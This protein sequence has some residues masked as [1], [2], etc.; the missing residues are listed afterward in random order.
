MGVAK[1]TK[2][3]KKEHFDRLQAI[4]DHLPADFDYQVVV[5]LNNEVLS[6]RVRNVRYGRAID[7]RILEALEEIANK[8]KEENSHV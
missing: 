6:Q 1:H 7:F 8:H 3:Q 2:E 4:E 5:K